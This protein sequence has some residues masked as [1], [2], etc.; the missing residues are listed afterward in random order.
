MP[1][2]ES[3]LKFL[4]K[5]A[6][7]FH[8]RVTV[9]G[10]MDEIVVDVN[11]AQHG[12]VNMI[13]RPHLVMFNQRVLVVA[14]DSGLFA[15]PALSE[16]GHAGVRRAV[17]VNV[18]VDGGSIA[19]SEVV[20]FF[21]KTPLHSADAA[22]LLKHLGKSVF[23]REP[24]ALNNNDRRVLVIA[25]RLGDRLDAGEETVRLEREGVA[26]KVVVEVLQEVVLAADLLPH[27][28]W[29]LNHNPRWLA[30]LNQFEKAA[31]ASA[32]RCLHADHYWLMLAL[33]RQYN[34][35]GL[36]SSKSADRRHGSMCCGFVVRRCD[37]FRVS[38]VRN[39]RKLE[40]HP[41]RK[42]W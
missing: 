34:L 2:V 25:H 8:H 11:A 33:V 35:I 19:G 42:R 41:S 14:G 22:L 12:L 7:L 23:V 40:H 17:Q 18:A 20:P 29:L 15:S 16:T 30:L 1:Q 38:R 39:T 37:T 36:V 21:V 24:R 26:L 3:S 28:H 4:N 10:I 31:L 9:V 27:L 13:R 6:Q 32:D 5:F